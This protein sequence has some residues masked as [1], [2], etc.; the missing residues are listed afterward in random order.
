[1]EVSSQGLR[2][3]AG[4]IYPSPRFLQMFHDAGVPV[5]LASDG[6]VPEQAGWG[7]GEVVAAAR[8]AGYVSRL[9]FDRRRRT[10]VPL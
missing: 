7:H 10:P 3:P 2:N 4:E 6:H 8:A 9:S 5:T 1:V